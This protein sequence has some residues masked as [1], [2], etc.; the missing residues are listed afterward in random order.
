MAR[1]WSIPVV[2]PYGLTARLEFK[3]ALMLDPNGEPRRVI[4]AADG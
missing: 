2:S 1:D 4:A 3:S